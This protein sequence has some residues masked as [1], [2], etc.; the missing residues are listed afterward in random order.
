MR[1]VAIPIATK[2]SR[3]SLPVGD[4]ASAEA[5]DRLPMSLKL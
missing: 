4:D 5:N 2:N 1:A 3:I